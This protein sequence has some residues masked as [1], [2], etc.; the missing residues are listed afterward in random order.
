MSSIKSISEQLN[1]FEHLKTEVSGYFGSLD[2]TQLAWKPAA[3]NW[4]IAECLKH[5]ITSNETYFPVFDKILA[6]QQPGFWERWNPLSRS[7]GKNMVKTLSKNVSRKFKSPQLF[8]P[9][10][11]IVD[12]DILKDFSEHQDKLMEKI[13]GLSHFEVKKIIVSSPVSPLITL[14]LADC[15]EVLAGHE[16]RHIVQ[17]VRVMQHDNFPSLQN[18]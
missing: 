12:N 17:A 10:K 7:I 11:I 1:R 14:P 3:N 18:S 15:I 6:G 8:L 5:I 9:G 13:R 4:S 16:E 2:K